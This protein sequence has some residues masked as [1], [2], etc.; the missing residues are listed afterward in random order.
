MAHNEKTVLDLLRTIKFPGMNRDI[1]DYGVVQGVT[2]DGNRAAVELEVLSRDE[3]LPKQIFRDVET[4]L[5]GAGLEPTIDLKV[6]N[7]P[8]IRQPGTPAGAPSGGQLGP[9][10]TSSDP[11]ADRQGI[12]DVRFIIAVASGK[13]GVGKSTVAV[14]LAY[15]LL[16]QGLKVGL[17]DADVYG[18][19]MPI[20]LGIEDAPIEADEQ[21]RIRPVVKDGLKTIS[22]GYMIHDDQPVIWRGPLVMKTIE[23]FLRGVGWGELDVLVIDLPP[24]T[25]DAQ[26]SLVQKVPIDGA[27][28]VTTPSKVAIADVIRGHAMFEKVDVPTIGVVENMSYLIVPSTGERLTI[29]GDGGG[30]KAAAER[31]LPFL[32]EVPLDAATCEAGDLGKPIVVHAPE[33]PQSL[34]FLDI[35]RQVWAH[36]TARGTATL[37]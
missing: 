35:A 29:F 14:N 2:V 16:A 21:K 33:N 1:V 10:G 7:F 31:G 15:A 6:K 32:G 28:I 12:P 11:W 4:A 30:R 3:S 37:Q 9:H 23:Q 19:S 25:G 20:M 27:V 18:P 22:I 17:L 5:K 34:A 24:G 8:Q 26:L 36:L 13:G